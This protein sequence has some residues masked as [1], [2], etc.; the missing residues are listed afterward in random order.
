L[1]A[2]FDCTGCAVC[3]ESCPDDALVMVDYNDTPHEDL[4][5]WF[6]YAR[7]LERKRTIANP[8]DKF[9]VKGSQ[10]EQPLFEFSGACSGCGET[11]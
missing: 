9:T 6:S 7:N 8:L 10:F 2:P 4:G 3:V 11:P 5:D 1:V